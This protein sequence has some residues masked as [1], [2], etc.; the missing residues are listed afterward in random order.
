MK[1]NFYGFLKVFNSLSFHFRIENGEYK[2]TIDLA[3]E[4]EKV[5]A[6]DIFHFKSQI[7]R[8]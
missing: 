4:S 5:D 3:C 2:S 6:H 8:N 7:G 1:C